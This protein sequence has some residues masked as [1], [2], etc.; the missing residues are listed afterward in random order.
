[1]QSST[2]PEKQKA[3]AGSDLLENFRS[4]DRQFIQNAGEALFVFDQEDGSLIEINRQ[5]ETL[6]GYTQE[7]AIRLSFKVLFSREYQQR[8][9][10]LIS[11]VIKQGAAEIS[12]IKF[13]RAGG[14]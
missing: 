8:I 9:L 13:R 4:R 11:T 5:A 14:Y 1:M 2:T 6:L 7:S 10:R 3:F 12:D